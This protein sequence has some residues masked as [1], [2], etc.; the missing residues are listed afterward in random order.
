MEALTAQQY[1]L[2][3]VGHDPED[4]LY[5]ILVLVRWAYVLQSLDGVVRVNGLQEGL[6]E[7][8]E[9]AEG[10]EKPEIAD[11]IEDGSVE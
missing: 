1:L 3:G 4:A 5:E 2:T 11:E 10:F 7:Q 6:G 8:F 9:E